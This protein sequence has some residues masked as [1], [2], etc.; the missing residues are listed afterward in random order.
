[1]RCGST[2]HPMLYGIR[3]INRQL[4]VAEKQA[5]YQYVYE[6]CI[7]ANPGTFFDS[8]YC[9]LFPGRHEARVW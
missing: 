7:C 5:A 9:M 3:A 2:Q 6:E 4:I 1:M 8:S